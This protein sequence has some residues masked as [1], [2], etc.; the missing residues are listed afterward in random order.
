[1]ND[2]ELLAQITAAEEPDHCGNC[3]SPDI[4]LE[5]SAEGWSCRSCK[6]SDSDE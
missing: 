4:Y 5:S 3:G 6:A 1:M 2:E